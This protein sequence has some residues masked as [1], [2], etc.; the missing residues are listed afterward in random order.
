MRLLSYRIKGNPGPSRMG[1]L[2][3]EKIIDLQKAWKKFKHANNDNDAA[4]T[5]DRFFPADPMQFF[6]AGSRMIEQAQDVLIYAKYNR[7]DDISFSR[8]QVYLFTPLSSPGKIICVG[9]NYA[10]HAAEMDSNV[11]DYPVLFAKFAN[12]LIGPEDV[13]EKPKFVNKLDYEAELIAVIGKE[14]SHVRRDKAFDYI[15]GYTIGNDMSAR[16]LQKRT[17]QW[18]QGKTLDRSTPVGPWVVTPDE[19][20]DV[21]NLAVRSYVN[22]EERQSATT[23]KLIFDIP[24]L[25]EFISSLV[26]LNPGDLIMTGTPDGVG[27]GMTPPQFVND[28]D[29]V[30]I[31]IDNIG[32]IENKVKEK[33]KIQ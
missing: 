12:A 21:G 27:M 1:F 31:E 3:G 33:A 30:T 28:G 2:H 14:A 25:I 24:F 15:A 18:L 29:I 19:V 13:I 7:V 16:D 22:G 8:D 10:A 5:A 6:T 26:T 17:P 9:K 23:Q 32:R 11:P 4:N 20:G